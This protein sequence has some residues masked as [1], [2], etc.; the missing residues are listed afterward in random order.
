MQSGGGATDCMP[1][2]GGKQDEAAFGER[3]SHAF[4]L[5][6]SACCLA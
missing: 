1:A 3:S 2:E 5:P 4:V 6:P